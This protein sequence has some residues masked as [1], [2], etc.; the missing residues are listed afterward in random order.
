[1]GNLDRQRLLRAVAP[2]AATIVASGLYIASLAPSL[3][4]RIRV[5]TAASSWPLPSQTACPT[6]PDTRSTFWSSKGG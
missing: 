5:L 2:G 6:R 3:P 4:G 1:M